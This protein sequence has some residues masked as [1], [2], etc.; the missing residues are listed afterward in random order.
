MELTKD[1]CHY[2]QI[3]RANYIDACGNTA[4]QVAITYT[5]IIDTEAPVVRTEALSGDLG[6]NP[7]VIDPVFTG[8]DNCEGAVDPVI[9]T[10]GPSNTGCSY[11]QTWTASYTDACGNVSEQISITNTW[12]QDTEIPTITIVPPGSVDM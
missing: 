8:Y 5:W 12:T 4:V 3:W 9:I 11:T 2:T 10:D 7:E 6:C 1:G